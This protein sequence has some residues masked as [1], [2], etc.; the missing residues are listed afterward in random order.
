MFFNPVIVLVIFE[1]VKLFSRELFLKK[2]S[3]E[4]DRGGHAVQIESPNF[5]Y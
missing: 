3:Y 1:N 4:A 5:Y 2:T